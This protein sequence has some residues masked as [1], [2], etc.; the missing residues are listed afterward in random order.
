MEAGITQT[1][2]DESNIVGLIDAAAPA[3]GPRGPY[4]TARKRQR[5]IERE[6][7]L[8]ELIQWL[9]DTAEAE[10]EAA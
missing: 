8:R 1:L 6:N 7:D 5:E 3:P 2:W 10:R 4:N 9:V